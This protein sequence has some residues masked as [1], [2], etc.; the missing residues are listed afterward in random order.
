MDDKPGLELLLGALQSSQL[1][2]AVK[3]EAMAVLQ[4]NGDAVNG[5][6]KPLEYQAPEIN[7]SLAVPVIARI[8]DRHLVS[9]FRKNNI[10]PEQGQAVSRLF[11]AALTDGMYEYQL[12]CAG[13]C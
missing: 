7:R 1:P 8:F 12:R 4:Q 2:V 3:E 9:V 10:A 5:L 11:Y 6:V 13:L